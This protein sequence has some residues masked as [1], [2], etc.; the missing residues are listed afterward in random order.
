MTASFRHLF[1]PKLKATAALGFVLTVAALVVVPT[2]AYA[3][4]SSCYNGSCESVSGTGLHISSTDTYASAPHCN[5]T[6]ATE[7]YDQKGY[8][9]TEEVGPYYQSGCSTAPM[10]LGWNATLPANDNV[11]GTSYYSSSWQGIATVNVHS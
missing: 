3:D 9:S 10:P 4:G 5:Q 6:L 2:A 7:Q 1:S 8:I 11:Y